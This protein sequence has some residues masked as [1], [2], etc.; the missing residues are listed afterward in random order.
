MTITE[1]LAYVKGLVEGLELDANKPEVKVL[2]A[3]VE[4]L[5]DVTLTVSDL[6][7]GY[8]DLADQL[9]AVDEDLCSLEEDFYENGLGY[10]GEK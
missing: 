8:D 7:A 1:K 2:A 5:D 3:I 6:D 10:Y 4:L 9:D